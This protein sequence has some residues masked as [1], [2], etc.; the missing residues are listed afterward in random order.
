MARVL[1]AGMLGIF[2]RPRLRGWPGKGFALVLAG[3]V[4]A[5]ESP[6]CSSAATSAAPDPDERSVAVGREG[7]ASADKELA[8]A[9]PAVPAP[10]LDAASQMRSGSSSLLSL[11]S[12][13]F[14]PAA[15]TQP[16][17][18][19]LLQARTLVHAPF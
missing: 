6:G 5:L 17:A 12:A 18:Y 7:P 1:L 8:P 19:T 13:L 15:S 10:C 9:P 2:S 3:P 4:K 14:L 16:F 11:A